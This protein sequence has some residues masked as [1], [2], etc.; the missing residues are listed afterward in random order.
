MVMSN[1]L[2][3]LTVTLLATI[4]PAAC[5]QQES[6]PA[7]KLPATAK[8]PMLRELPDPFK[9]NDGKRIKSP[10]Q[11][12]ARRAE[13]LTMALQYEYGRIPEKVDP[14]T[15]ERAEPKAPNGGRSEEYILKM[16]PEGKVSTHL[17]LTLPEGKGP[18]PVIVKGDL[19]WGRVAPEI[20]STITSRRYA[21]AEFDRTEIAADKNDRGVG[22]FPLYPEYDWGVLAA[23]AWGYGRVDDYLVTRPDIDKTKLIVT[24]HS[25]GGKAALLAGALDERVALTVPNGSGC[26][27]A[28]L[29]RVEWPTSENIHAIVKNFP[30]WFGPH[31][32]EF[33]GHVDQLPFDQHE[34]KALIAP[35]ALY[36]T[37]SLDDLW[38]N[39]LGTQISF[40]A[41]R[42][43]FTFLGA[44]EKTGLH[45]RHGKHEQNAE[46]FAAL[47]DFADAKL[48]G[49][50]V[51]AKFDELPFPT[52]PS[53]Y[54]WK[55][56]K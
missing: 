38:A 43:V 25:R 19:C 49:K 31:F 21:L 32:D 27:G 17:I 42:E 36:T 18:F 30:F 23:W 26:G 29:F 50:K 10:D 35:R 46:D 6:A 47:L 12:P 41:S 1:K 24:G 16:G 28:G 13:I 40:L 3:A 37:D 34:I 7:G 9:L 53:A 22:V 11:W 4:A 51:A 39:P 8:L 56:P 15:A 14:V 55:A 45:Y 5:A 52:T 2:L 44:G 20:I 48:L 33:V 54:S